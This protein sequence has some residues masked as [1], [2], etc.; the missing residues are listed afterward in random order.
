[1]KKILVSV[2]LF[3]MMFLSLV[4]ASGNVVN[5]PDDVTSFEEFKLRVLEA[6]QG[7]GFL[8]VTT[9]NYWGLC[10]QTCAN[11]IF[12]GDC[13]PCSYGEVAS[14]RSWHPDSMSVLDTWTSAYSYCNDW[15]APYNYYNQQAFCTVPTPE[16]SGGAD[17]GDEKCIGDEVW[18][19]S[20]SGTWGFSNDCDYGCSGGNCQQQQCSDHAERKC[21]GDSVYWY[22]SCGDRQ[23]E[24]ERCESDEECSGSSCVRVCDDGFIGEKL[25]SGSQVVQQYQTSD[26]STDI[27]TIEQCDYNCENSVCTV[28]Q[29]DT[30]S[31]PTSWSQCDGD[32]MFRTNYKCDTTTN[33]ECVQF[34]EDES[35]EC[36]T[37]EQCNYDETCEDSVCVD[38]QCEE[39]EIADNHECIEVSAFSTEMIVWIVVGVVAFIFIIIII[40]LMVMLK[41][42]QNKKK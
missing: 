39:G 11:R 25:C 28:P 3:S 42:G 26:C 1:M 2:L 10:Q 19:C 5:I 15:L 34:T 17:P 6:N 32:S 4:S 13:N 29:C 18:E 37:S 8:A 22:D 7:E 12:Q 40:T 35:C 16:C 38:V 24:Y 21:S 27:R 31:A 41:G 9:G 33:Y 14:M 36:G 23:E 30:C 20:S